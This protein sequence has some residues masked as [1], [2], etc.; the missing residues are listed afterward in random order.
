MTGC[1]PDGS[2]IATDIRAGEKA[3]GKIIFDVPTAEGVIILPDLLGQSPGTQGWA[4][5]FPAE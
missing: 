3:S 5:V 2:V 1:L 4:W